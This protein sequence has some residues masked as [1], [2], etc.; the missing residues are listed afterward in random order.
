MAAFSALR[1]AGFTDVSVVDEQGA[2]VTA[3]SQATAIL[4][5]Q[6]PAGSQAAANDP[7]AVVIRVPTTPGG[8][9][10]GGGGGGGAGNNAG[11]GVG[12]SNQP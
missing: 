5:T 6:P 1:A 12:A 7:V 3:P 10:G 8:D 4:G 9:N 11:N 2:V